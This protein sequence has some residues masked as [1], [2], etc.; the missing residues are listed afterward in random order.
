MTDDLSTSH[1]HVV[2]GPGRSD[3]L[4]PVELAGVHVRLDDRDDGFTLQLVVGVKQLLVQDAVHVD[5]LADGLVETELLEVGKFSD[6]V[7]EN[8][9]L[10]VLAVV[11][12]V[13][14]SSR[15]RRN[16]TLAARVSSESNND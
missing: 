6:D 14:E 8:S 10:G 12:A 11:E 16:V 5:T 1:L 7:G 9:G 4:G 2:P 13:E 3:A 15:V